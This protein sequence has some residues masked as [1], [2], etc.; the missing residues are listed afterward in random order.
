MTKQ[1]MAEESA[2]NTT[3]LMYRQLLGYRK[4]YLVAR[5][6]AKRTGD[7]TNVPSIKID[8]MR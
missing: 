6:E 5:L 4:A 1:Q 2:G 3:S 7:Y 8:R